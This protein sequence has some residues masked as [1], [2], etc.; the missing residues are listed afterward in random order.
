MI[1]TKQERKTSSQDVRAARV[2]NVIQGHSRGG[3]ENDWRSSTAGF[4][5]ARYALVGP[6]R[7]LEPI[8]ESCKEDGESWRARN[9]ARTSEAD[10][11]DTRGGR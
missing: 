2:Q 5:L 1:A 3:H 4:P 7:H 9:H 6:D 11:A 10:A 8:M